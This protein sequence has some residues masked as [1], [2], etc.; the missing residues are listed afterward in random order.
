VGTLAWWISDTS[1][2][3]IASHK[4]NPSQLRESL[5]DPRVWTN[6]MPFNDLLRHRMQP[7]ANAVTAQRFTLYALASTIAVMAVIANACR[8]YSNFYSIAVYLG[9]SGRSV[10]VRPRLYLQKACLTPIFQFLANFCVVLALVSG[11][12]LQKIFFGQLQSREVEVC[13]L[14]ISRDI[15]VIT[16]PIAVV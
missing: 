5:Y 8:N 3:R 13:S 9:R 12:V 15:T 1:S 14:D 6:T 10:L 11:K 4:F 2:L 16:L 7:L